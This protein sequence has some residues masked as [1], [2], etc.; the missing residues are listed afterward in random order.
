MTPPSHSSKN[1]ASGPWKQRQCGLRG[2]GGRGGILSIPS[3]SPKTENTLP[4]T[5]LNETR[6]PLAVPCSPHAHQNGTVQR[7]WTTTTTV[8]TGGFPRCCLDHQLL[9][10]RSDSTSKTQ[11]GTHNRHPTTPHTRLPTRYNQALVAGSSPRPDPPFHRVFLLSAVHQPTL[12]IGRHHPPVR[13]PTLG[14]PTERAADILKR[15][16]LSTLQTC[17]AILARLN[18]LGAIQT[19]METPK[20]KLQTTQSLPH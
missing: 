10:T 17:E 3:R 12:V 14:L 7:R 6:L 5:L 1:M 2:A 4:Q 18:H 9:P 8:T 15:P 20:V 11:N 19:Q 16:C 13:T